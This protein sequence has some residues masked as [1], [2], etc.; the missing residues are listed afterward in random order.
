[1]K[2]VLGFFRRWRIGSTF[3]MPFCDAARRDSSC[4]NRRESCKEP[5]APPR[6]CISPQSPFVS[7]RE[8]RFTVFEHRRLTFVGSKARTPAC[9]DSV[10]GTRSPNDQREL[11]GGGKEEEEEERTESR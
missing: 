10:T 5:D 11:Q 4:R 3:V 8:T 7:G 9:G 6:L 2:T 1:M